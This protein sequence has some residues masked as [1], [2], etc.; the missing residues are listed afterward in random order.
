MRDNPEVKGMYLTSPTFE[1]V[2]TDISE[3][4]KLLHE[5]NKVLLVDEAHGAHFCCIPGFP[6][7]ALSMGADIVVQ[8]LHKTLPSPTQTAIVHI[9]GS[10]ISQERMR[11]ALN[12]FQSTSPS[13]M[14]MAAMDYC[15]AFLEE[16]PKEFFES[17]RD[18]LLEYRKKL[19]Q[20]SS[21]LLLDKQEGLWDLDPA[22]IVL[23][24]RE[25]LSAPALAHCLRK[26]CGIEL[27][28]AFGGNLVGISTIADSR[29][30]FQR[31]YRGICALDSRIQAGDKKLFEKSGN[32]NKK[33]FE[34]HQN[35][36]IIELPK[37]S[38]TLR[39]AFYRPYEAV[40]LAQAGGRVSA[41]FVTP[42]PPGI[43]I[44]CPGEILSERE[45]SMIREAVGRGEDVLGMEGEGEI[46]VLSER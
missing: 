34:N 36:D 24:S 31:F 7:T 25:E 5:H 28:G 40:S 45:L 8:S 4:A 6:K 15:R 12:A 43:P 33:E 44:V 39:D 22:K 26:D 17:Y 23:H 41:A 3:I 18:M 38:R 30:A 29:D 16:Q 14:F 37:V 35:Y 10:R 42:Y 1:G 11:L 46:L 2:V 19:Q 21:F 32:F 9:Q 20:V 27:E 13:Y